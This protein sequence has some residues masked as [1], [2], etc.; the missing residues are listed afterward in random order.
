MASGPRGRWFVVLDCD[1]ILDR[2]AVESALEF[3]GSNE[4]SAVGL[5]PGMKCTGWLPR[6]LAPSME[7]LLQMIRV[8]E[9][10]RG[11]AGDAAADASFMLMNREAFDVVNRMNR[12]PGILNESG[13]NVWSYQVEGLRTFEGDGSRWMWREVNVRTWASGSP[14]PAL[15]ARTFIAGS[16]AVAAISVSGLIYGFTNRI[17]NFAGASV[18][19]FSAVSYCLMGVSYYLYARRLRSP[20]WFAPLW[21]LAHIPA[22]ILTLLSISSAS[23]SGSPRPGA[24][25]PTSGRRTSATGPHY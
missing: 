25:A 4:V 1:V 6:L 23:D 22:T 14:Q 8:I 17:D 18:L 24:S 20:G 11:K 5:R 19:A 9:G 12:M 2:F 13:W 3:A 10:R 7:Y 15:R 21:A 16:G